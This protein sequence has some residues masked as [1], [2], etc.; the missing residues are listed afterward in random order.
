MN[1]T[2][3]KQKVIAVFKQAHPC[4]APKKGFCNA[5]AWLFFCLAPVALSAQAMN[6]MFPQRSPKA[7]VS[8]V[9]GICTV[10][11]EYHRPGIRN[12]PIW[13][14]L[15]PFG[16]VWRTGAN[17]ATT[18]SFSHAV[19]IA[20]KP[21]PAGKYALFTIPGRDRWTIILNKRHHQIGTFEY[22]PSEDLLRFDVRPIATSFSEY[23]TFEIYPASDA[24][25]YVDLDWEKLRIYFL[26]EVDIDKA[27]EA[28]MKEILTNA[29]PNDWLPPCEAAQYLLDS[30]KDMPQAM[31]LIEESI[32]IRQMP[33][34]IFVKA[35]ILRWAGSAAEAHKAINQA[36]ELANKQKSPPA[37][38]IPIEQMRSQWLRGDQR[39]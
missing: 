17:E 27:V 7:S 5:V 12:R 21:V 35:Q 34:N 33:Q 19:K 30:E 15:V 36:L 29:R 24:S 10:T 14:E 9:V 3:A 8:Q 4:T 25:A 39:R 11:I 1:S 16:E 37:V 6:T 31:K 28:R 38:V 23:L 20:G 18:I 32:K 13:G 22:D 2:D 26:V